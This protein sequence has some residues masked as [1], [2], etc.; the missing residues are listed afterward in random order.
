MSYDMRTEQQSTETLL[1]DV[2]FI[3]HRQ[4]WVEIRRFGLT[5]ND[6]QPGVRTQD[7]TVGG[8]IL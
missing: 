7:T 4:S 3:R 6:A 1:P 2:Q 5:A 8:K